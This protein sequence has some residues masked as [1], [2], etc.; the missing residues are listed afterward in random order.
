MATTTHQCSPLRR[1][2]SYTP[3]VLI[4][5]TREYLISLVERFDEKQ[6]RQLAVAGDM[7]QVW[8]DA[9][10]IAALNRIESILE[11]LAATA[12]P[13][14]LDPNLS[15]RDVRQLRVRRNPGLL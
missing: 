4:E 2:P 5:Q 10:P 6:L 3:G 13:P 9:S 14:D 11:P 12:R 8:G 7:I 1:K 15:P